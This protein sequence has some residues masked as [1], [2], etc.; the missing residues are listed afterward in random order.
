MTTAGA[1]AD[2]EPH[3]DLRTAEIPK[4][5]EAGSRAAR[6]EAGLLLQEGMAVC[7]EAGPLLQEGMAVCP[8]AGPLLQEGMVV[9]PEAGR[10]L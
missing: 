6:L 9:C 5:Q 8:E 1:C 2:P 10:L 7:P 4:A 3:R